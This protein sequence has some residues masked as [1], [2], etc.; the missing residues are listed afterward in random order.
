M[1]KRWVVA[2]AAAGLLAGPALAQEKRA[3]DANSDHWKS[4]VKQGVTQ[5]REGA[6][7]LGAEAKR[8]AQEI[9]LIREVPAS[10]Y[11]AEK[12]FTLDGIVT[13]A[14]ANKVTIAREGLPAA[15]LDVGERTRLTL[16]GK[17]ISAKALPE[18]ARVRA[19]FQLSGD[20]PV[21][22][23]VEATTGSR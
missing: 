7:K 17:T 1:G 8:E 19:T 10:T 11:R 4:D 21:A 13:H 12:A 15:S 22:V 6:E 20:N 3:A 5:A 14:S 18:G 23:S 2:V 9:G 16:D